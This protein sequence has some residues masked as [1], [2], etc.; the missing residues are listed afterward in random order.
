[1][2]IVLEQKFG[3]IVC[4]PATDIQVRMRDYIISHVFN[5]IAEED[6]SDD[7]N[8]GKSLN[9][10]SLYL[11]KYYVPCITFIYVWQRYVSIINVL[12][13]IDLRRNYC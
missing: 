5:E 4:Q 13:Y 11:I 12:F 3:Q 9:T 10:H 2:R 7:E 1:M 6:Q 8:E